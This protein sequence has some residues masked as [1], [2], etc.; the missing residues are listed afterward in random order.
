MKGQ[1]RKHISLDMSEERSLEF[2]LKFK[3][4]LFSFSFKVD[5]DTFDRMESFVEI[6]KTACSGFTFSIDDINYV[7]ELKSDM[8]DFSKEIIIIFQ[9]AAIIGHDRNLTNKTTVKARL[10]IVPGVSPSSQSSSGSS[11][12]ADINAVKMIDTVHKL[13]LLGRHSTLDMNATST[14]NHIRALHDFQHGMENRYGMNCTLLVHLIASSGLM[15]THSAMQLSLDSFGSRVLFLPMVQAEPSGGVT[16]SDFSKGM[17]V[18]R[19]YSSFVEFVSR[20][21]LTAATNLTGD[22]RWAVVSG[23]GKTTKLNDNIKDLFIVI[24]EALSGAA[25]ITESSIITN[26]KNGAPQIILQDS[27]PGVFIYKCV[28]Q[29]VIDFRQANGNVRITIVTTDTNSHSTN[30]MPSVAGNSIV[31]IASPPTFT[32]VR[33]IINPHETIPAD[34][35]IFEHGRALGGMPLKILVNLHAD[36]RRILE[37][38]P[39]WLAEYVRRVGSEDLERSSIVPHE[40]TFLIRVLDLVCFKLLGNSQSTTSDKLSSDVLRALVLHLL[41]SMGQTNPTHWEYLTRYGLAHTCISEC[42]NLYHRHFTVTEAAQNML[43]DPVSNV[44]DLRSYGIVRVGDDDFAQTLSALPA[45]G[46]DEPLTRLAALVIIGAYEIPFYKLLAA[47]T[48]IVSPTERLGWDSRGFTTEFYHQLVLIYL[49]ARALARPISTG[50]G[51]NESMP[52][53]LAKCQKAVLQYWAGGLGMNQVLDKEEITALGGTFVAVDRAPL[54]EIIK[55]TGFA[56]DIE[57]SC[58]GLNHMASMTSSGASTFD[59]WL[60]KNVGL[61]SKHSLRSTVVVSTTGLSTAKLNVLIVSN[62]W[63][64]AVGEIAVPNGFH[65]RIELPSIAADMSYP[66]FIGP[67]IENTR[68]D[69]VACAKQCGLSPCISSHTKHITCHLGLY[70]DDSEQAN[71]K[72]KVDLKCNL[73]SFQTLVAKD[74]WSAQYRLRVQSLQHL[75]KSLTDQDSGLSCK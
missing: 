12:D 30:Y 38:R 60:S 16:A 33:Y 53:R 58:R 49:I 21:L 25:H 27:K 74:S 65:V 36:T 11:A 59:G 3:T 73:A 71:S 8:S 66:I 18:Q 55:V 68:Q 48:S 17:L 43:L 13:N 5:D 28:R 61:Q 10:T 1:K 46:H 23:S 15:K 45:D 54:D 4:S 57:I 40:D 44:L 42:R 41:P 34:R 69:L 72:A 64:E 2:E 9:K 31:S 7:A 62:P 47:L 50:K 22:Q 24:D 39:M 51:G 6:H 75:V 70:A 35:H 32:L 29:A 26:L 20:S 56:P 52:E 67:K 14:A 63:V 19:N 37:G